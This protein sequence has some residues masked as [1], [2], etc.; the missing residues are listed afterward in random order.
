MKVILT[1]SVNKLGKPGDVVTVADGYGRN[2]LLPRKFAML[3]DKGSLKIAER[4]AAEHERQEARLRTDAQSLAARLAEASVSISARA[5][6]DT[7]KLYGSVTA[8][9]IADAIQQQLGIEVD[10]RRID[11]PE[12]IH[13]LGE[14]AVPIRLHTDVTAEIK[15]NVVPVEA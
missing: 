10:R 15:V 7:T 9:N 11:L 14:Y 4:L 12:S 8:A 6:Q 3:A 2:Y 13:D 1:Q 5:G